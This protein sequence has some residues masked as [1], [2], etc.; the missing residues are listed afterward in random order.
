MTPEQLK[1][2]PSTFYRVAVKCLVF[3]D[4]GRLL[5]AE[6]E[7]GEFELPGGGWEH[8]E[9]LEECIQRELQEE[10]GVRAA[11]IGAVEMVLQG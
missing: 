10:L 7:D 4:T 1:N 9:S 8:G 3:D 6:N 11:N 2:L 5:V